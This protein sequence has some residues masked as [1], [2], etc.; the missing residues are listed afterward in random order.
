[1]NLPASSRSASS[2]R[3]YARCLS[4]AGA[5]LA[6]GA[7]GGLLAAHRDAAMVPPTASPITTGTQ[8][9][10]ALGPTQRRD[11]PR[12]ATPAG[13]DPSRARL[14]AVRRQQERVGHPLGLIPGE[15]G[16]VYLLLASH[17]PQ[18]YLFNG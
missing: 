6:G 9:I 18:P 13:R 11:D 2:T 12:F 8:I 17:Q 1:M 14:Y 3:R 16:L 10:R 15:G 5:G 4:V 7:G